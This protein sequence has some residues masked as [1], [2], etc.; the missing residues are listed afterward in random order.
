MPMV[1]GYKEDL[2]DLPANNRDMPAESLDHIAQ[3]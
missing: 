1:S 3:I 2:D